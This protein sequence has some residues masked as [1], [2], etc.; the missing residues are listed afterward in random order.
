VLLL[1]G[2]L[3]VFEVYRS[4]WECLSGLVKV[5]NGGVLSL[6]TED[7]TRM[8]A[9]FLNVLCVAAGCLACFVGTMRRC[10]SC[11]CAAT[12]WCV[13]VCVCVCV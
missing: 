2:S 6:T 3:L 12:R 11:A 10:R 1:G 13:C 5:F 4:G 8:K 7:L 9:S